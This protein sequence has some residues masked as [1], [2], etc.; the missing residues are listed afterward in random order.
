MYFKR[1]S[2]KRGGSTGIA[3]LTPSRQGYAGGGNIGGG[4]IGGRNLGTRTGF[5]IILNE[6]GLPYE[7]PP[8]TYKPNFSLRGGSYKPVNYPLTVIPKT[9]SGF[10]NL[11]TK[12]P[13]TS[14]GAAA[15][16]GTGIGQLANWVTRSTDTPAAYAERKKITLEDPFTYDETNLDVGEAFER[17]KEKQKIGEAP[18]FFPRGGKNKFYEDRNLDP[19]TG[20]AI[21]QLTFKEA[22]DIR[23][24]YQFNQANEIVG[25]AKEDKTIIELG[26]DDSSITLDPLKEIEREKNFLNK[27]LANKGLERGEAALVAAKAIG[28]AGSFKD[29][30]DAAVD[31]ALPIVRKRNE[32]DKAVTLTA[33][34]AFK[35]KEATQA[36]ASEDTTGIKELKYQATQ[37]LKSGDKSRGDTPDEVVASL[38]KEK[39][40]S[41]NSAIR[42][43]QLEKSQGTIFETFESIRDSKGALDLY[44]K[45]KYTN[46]GK[47][48][49]AEDKKLLAL[50]K[51]LAQD[52][53]TFKLFSDV[54]EFKDQYSPYVNAMKKLGFKEGGRV[55]RAIGSPMMGEQPVESQEII[56]SQTKT[57]GSDTQEKPVLN[58]SYDELRNRLPREITDDVVELLSNSEEALQDFAYIISQNDVDSFNL[59]YGV[60]LVIPPAPQTA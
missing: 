32:Q 39:F 14:Y 30:L 43:S 49:N 23:Q 10:V 29:K 37:L 48:I 42:S 18:G 52:L 22:D 50:Q 25:R 54:P 35:E 31:M 55:K 5:N 34:K 16:I 19:E 60:N 2:F 9:P 47:Q 13:K 17:I 44:I 11:M 24:N 58:L 45:E 51:Q 46:K 6:F 8:S 3:Q 12:F 20:L 53:S 26:G 1:P 7:K 36:K 15:G 57:I 59:K 28:T 4:G 21:D 27:L 33:Y 56:S 38:I 41:P 40:T